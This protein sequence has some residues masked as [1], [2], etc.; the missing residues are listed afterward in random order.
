MWDVSFLTRDRTNAPF[1]RNAVLIIGPEESHYFYDFW[2]TPVRT[3]EVWKIDHT[4]GVNITVKYLA[5]ILDSLF[6]II[7]LC[8]GPEERNLQ[9]VTCENY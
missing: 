2:F 8:W 4:E 7:L 3:K 9:I 1:I 5:A 6:E